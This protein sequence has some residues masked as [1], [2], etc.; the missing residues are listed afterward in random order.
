MTTLGSGI[1][2]PVGS[3][4]TADSE[5]GRYQGQEML[6]AASECNVIRPSDENGPWTETTVP[7]PRSRCSVTRCSTPGH[8]EV[9]PFRPPRTFVRVDVHRG[10][11]RR[12]AR[13]SGC[14]TNPDTMVTGRALRC[15]CGVRSSCRSHRRSSG[16]VRSVVSALWAA[17]TSWVHR[18]CTAT[19]TRIPN[20]RMDGDSQQV[21]Q[22]LC[23]VLL[24][25]GEVGELS[26]VV[27]PSQ[28]NGHF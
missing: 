22:F 4:G 16:P 13:R 27:I 17:G 23:S 12:R 26:L 5:T 28:D 11:R 3:A 18:S 9:R 14:G 1:A 15:T 8:L 2:A 19:T 24:T 25:S 20:I 10:V 6:L 7:S 21:A